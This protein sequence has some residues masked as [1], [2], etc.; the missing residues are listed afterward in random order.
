[1]PSNEA[2]IDESDLDGLARACARRFPTA[3]SQRPFAR[4]VGLDADPTEMDDASATWEQMLRAAQA[5]GR[6]VD[7]A[8]ALARAAPGDENLVALA[9]ALGVAAA[10]STRSPSP[11]VLGLL[12]MVLVVGAVLAWDHG[13]GEETSAATSTTT[14][15]S[16]STVTSTAPASTAT[17]TE[18]PAE[19]PA[20]APTSTTTST[21]PGTVPAQAKE[22][23]QAKQPAPAVATRPAG[24]SA[25]SGYFYAGRSSP[26]D[27][28]DTITLGRDARVRAD[29]PRAANGHNAAAP[30]RCVLTRGTVIALSRAPIDASNGHYWVPVGDP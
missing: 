20:E 8:R 29:Y 5:R 23:A 24:R 11:L 25:C 17:S 12:G 3:E 2:Q 4:A 26:G 27:A 14:P 9:R 10:P 18:T 1:M 28:G 19:A 22:P 16:R 13:Q 7:L 6:L 15:A 30:E 21:A